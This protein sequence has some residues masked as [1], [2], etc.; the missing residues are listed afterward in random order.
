MET[1]DYLIMFYTLSALATT[2]AIVLSMEVFFL[3]RRVKELDR[4][5]DTTHEEVKNIK[6][7]LNTLK[8]RY[9]LEAE[10]IVNIS[11]KL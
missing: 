8:K 7:R 10:D 4:V 1:L 2:M 9:E 11:R 3:R 5:A 6:K